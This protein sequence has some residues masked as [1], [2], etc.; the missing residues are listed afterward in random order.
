ML[1]S[2]FKILSV[3]FRNMNFILKYSTNSD[4]NRYD[5]MYEN[6]II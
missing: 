1:N 6:V 3:R 5:F 4:N 2:K